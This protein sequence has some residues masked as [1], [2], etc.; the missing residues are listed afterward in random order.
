MNEKHQEEKF[1]IKIDREEFTLESPTITGAQ[2]RQLP[3]PSIGSGR[4]LFLTVP[5]P[6]PDLLITD[7]E[8]IQLKHGMHFFTAPVNI[9]PGGNAACG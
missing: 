5:G 7:D 9:T 2:L 6:D 8:V 1:E 4:D 3:D